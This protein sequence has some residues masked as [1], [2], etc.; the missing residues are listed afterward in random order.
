MKHIVLLCVLCTSLTLRGQLVYNSNFQPFNLRA[1]PFDSGQIIT[2]PVD[3][4]LFQTTDGK[5][6]GPVDSTMCIS[7]ELDPNSGQAAVPLYQIDRSKPLFI[8]SN[9]LLS[10]GILIPNSNYNAVACVFYSGP[11][12][13]YFIEGANCENDL[14]SGMFIELAIPDSLGH[15]LAASRLHTGYAK[16][17]ADLFCSG[18]QTC[19]PTE[20]FDEQRLKR[21]TLKFTFPDKPEVADQVLYLNF[22]EIGSSYLTNLVPE[23]PA[24]PWQFS[25]G[26]YQVPIESTVPFPLLDSYLLQYTASTYPSPQHLSYVEA[27][28]VPNADTQ[29][30]INLIVGIQQTLEIQPY[31]LLRG[32]LVAGSDSLRH[33]VTLIDDGGDFCLGAFTELIFNGGE[34]YRHGGG[35]IEM[36]HA[37]SCMQFRK[38]SAMRVL[39]NI[40]LAYGNRGAGML[41]LC[42]ES[43]LVLERGARLHFDG[44]LSLSECNDNPAPQEVLID[45][46]PGS[47]LRFTDRAQ[48]TNR[49]S[50]FGN[51]TLGVRMLGGTLD[52]SALPAEQR[53]LIRRIYPE[54]AP[55]FEQNVTF[56]PNP[57]VDEA[58]ITYVA[59]QE[60]KLL[61]RWFDAG[62]RQVK[63][64]NYAAVR[65]YNEWTPEG[66]ASAGVYLLELSGRDG[67]A[68]I[69]AVR[70]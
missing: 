61:L 69:K 1:C 17:S 57:F 66:P 2:T 31:T 70:N 21:I 58:R 34:E 8:Q 67:R 5:P 15:P 45:L 35:H 47:E 6:D 50:Q 33:H 60:E 53:S 37:R 46:L 3:W 41:V 27:T 7:V 36:Q 40:L 26:A 68:S 49:F 10:T 63:T 14:C 13:L 55:V 59:A 11:D 52:D 32:G 48:L 4:H 25:N 43:R 18:T 39:P 51:V 22:V 65:G 64:E 19:F 24:Y 38:G 44:M 54:P 29:Q 42:E 20:Y 23:V 56:S 9:D 62:G 16:H 28:P 30:T 12:S